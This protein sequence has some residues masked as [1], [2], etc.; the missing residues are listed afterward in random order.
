MSKIKAFAPANISCVF[1]ICPDK[2]PRWAGSLGFGFTLREGVIAEVSKSKTSEIFF[3]GKKI[4]FPTVRQIIELLTKEKITVNLFSPLPLG[5][6]F[7]LSGASALA[8]AYAIKKLLGLKK[9]NKQ[10]AIISHIAEVENQT[11]LGDVT[12]QY[13]GGFLIKFKPSSHFE[14]I[15]IPFENKSIFYSYLT[16]L[17]TKSVLSNNTLLPKIN[18]SADIELAKLQNLFNS[19]SKINFE[20]ILRISKEFAVNSGLLRDKKAI[21]TI[22][23]IEEK[24]GA[25]SMIMLGNAVFSN[26]DFKGAKKL[27][28][29]DQGAHVL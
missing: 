21:E 25:A 10:L 15:K 4:N 7:G 16:K 19:G 12:N 14:V 20:D 28:F 26:I 13:F 3:N 22:K 2:N 17:P 23:M 6:G 11:G 5:A 8:A 9:S 29:S 24:G 27:T 18:S 1:K